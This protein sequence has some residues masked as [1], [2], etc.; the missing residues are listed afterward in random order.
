MNI[1]SLQTLSASW[2]KSFTKAACELNYVQ[3]TVTM[4]IQQLEKE[5][6]YPLLT[7]SAK[8]SSLLTVKISLSTQTKFAIMQRVNN[9]GKIRRAKW[10]HWE[11]SSWTLL[12]GTTAY[13]FPS[14]AHYKN[15]E[16]HL[17]WDSL[18]TAASARQGQLDMLY[19]RGAEYGPRLPLLL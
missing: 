9:V 17:K 18:R 3:S 5:L 13:Y 7:E 11:Y 6:G 2:I 15:I 4:Q 16:V 12:S 19:I 8:D 10:R 14:T 1:R